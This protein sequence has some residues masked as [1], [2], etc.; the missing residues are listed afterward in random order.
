MS[1]N[2]LEVSPVWCNNK[3]ITYDFCLEAYECLSGT[4]SPMP[5]L[6]NGKVYYTIPTSPQTFLWWSSNLNKWVFSVTLGTPNN[7]TL[8]YTGD[9]PYTSTVKWDGDFDDSSYFRTCDCTCF[10]KPTYNGNQFLPI[11]ECGVITIYPMNI[12]CI[13]IPPSKVGGN[14]SL[15]LQIAGGTPPYSVRLLNTTGNVILSNSTL[16][17]IPNL[18]PGTYFVEI[19]DNF[20]DF[21]QVINCTIVAPP[22]PTP[23]PTP[24]PP[25]PSYP[26]YLFCMN[27]TFMGGDRKTY[28]YQFIFTIYSFTSINNIITPIFISNT[29]NEF[30]SWDS[31]NWSLSALTSSQL[32][33]SL[34]VQSTVNWNIVNTRQFQSPFDYSD[35]PFGSW[36]LIINQPIGSP[37]INSTGS[38]C[39]IP[40]LVF[41]INESWWQY[42]GSNIPS[43]YRGTTCG[44]DNETPYFR[45]M[46]QNLG[47]LTVT[48]Y[49]ILCTNNG[50]TY[51][52][53]TDI[54]SGQTGVSDTIP[55]ITSPT[56]PIINPTTGSGTAN[57]Q[58]WKGPCLPSLADPNFTVTLTATLSDAT[59]LTASI[60][61][62][63]CQNI[64]NGICQIN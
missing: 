15:S 61:F 21:Q 29:G 26:E 10:T 42:Y 7:I 30:V 60:N 39:P 28:S 44:G 22:P 59:T 63:Y 4:T 23:T 36:Q 56:P 5:T 3:I 27:I 25:I 45:W 6:Y 46:V 38:N 35:M 18:Q 52:D 34:G 31:N 14:G 37:I 50:N 33:T 47:G 1:K 24:L 58:G 9:Y 13:P 49:D 19:T 48:K 17:L 64:L 40:I 12:N 16:I 57:S 55:W 54:S 32:S 2:P 51:F 20:G 11:N 62:I 41:W 43:Q 8:D 53:V